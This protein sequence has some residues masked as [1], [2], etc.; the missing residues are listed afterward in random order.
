MLSNTSIAAVALSAIFVSLIGF[1]IGA[2]ALAEQQKTSTTTNILSFDGIFLKSDVNGVESNTIDLS[3]TNSLTLNGNS[4]NSTVN[5]VKSNTIELSSISLTTNSLTLEGNNLNSTVNEIKSNLI[6]IQIPIPAPVA[7]N[8]VSMD[9]AGYVKDSGISVTTSSVSNDNTHLMTSA[10]IQAAFAAGL[11]TK[12]PIITTLPIAKGGTGQTTANTALN[13]LLP[14]QAG[15]ANDF[16]TTD[17]TNTNWYSNTALANFSTTPSGTD[18]LGG[19]AFVSSTATSV[20]SEPMPSGGLSHFQNQRTIGFRFTVSIYIGVT[21]AK[22]ATQQLIVAGDSPWGIWELATGLLL[23]S[24]NLNPGTTPTNGFYVSQ[25]STQLILTPGDYVF[26]VYNS[27]IINFVLATPLSNNFP[28]SNLFMQDTFTSGFHFPEHQTSNQNLF[29]FG[30]F[31]YVIKPAS[32][33]IPGDLSLF[34]LTVKGSV[35]KYIGTSQ[36]GANGTVIIPHTRIASTDTILIT[37][38]LKVPASPAL[39][40][41]VVSIIPNVSFTVTSYSATNTVV[42]TDNSTFSYFI[43]KQN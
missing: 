6:Q 3:T 31:D 29:F 16:L 30:W 9:A 42:A 19:M 33:T 10:A 18:F 12:E 17:G 8:I 22:I 27:N 28:L 14:T 23:A 41:L 43:V 1:I 26:A 15:N 32:L 35:N 24:G 2:V 5:G 20:T 7:N 13:A 21:Q 40:F 37:R 38:T 11:A 36:L 25:L 39:G 34:S 4:L